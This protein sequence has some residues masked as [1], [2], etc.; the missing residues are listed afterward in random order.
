MQPQFYKTIKI[1]SLAIGSLTVVSIN[2][3]AQVPAT[4]EPASAAMASPS[5]TASGMPT[6]ESVRKADRAL[7]RN[8]YAALRNRDDIDAE[9]VSIVAHAGKVTF[10]GTVPDSAQIPKVSE[11]A[12][13]VP[14][15]VSVINKLTV[16]RPYGR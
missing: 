8:I 4:T 13:G 15:V 3:W 2:A 5:V 9:S 16:L 1:L 7:R 12:Q 14:G 10:F 11:T 6:A